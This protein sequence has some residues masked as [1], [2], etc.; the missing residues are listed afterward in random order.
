MRYRSV[1][2]HPL[3]YI[4]YTVAALAF[5]VHMKGENPFLYISVHQ[6]MMERLASRFMTDINAVCK[7]DLQKIRD[8]ERKTGFQSV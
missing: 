5:R 1:F 4:G 8:S 2:F 6:R 3:G 7:M